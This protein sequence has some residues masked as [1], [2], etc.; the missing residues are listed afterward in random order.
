MLLVLEP[1]EGRWTEEFKT[2]LLQGTLP[3]KDE[4]AEHV[5]CQATG[6]CIQDG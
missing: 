5:A 1:Q 6:Y 3:K 4:D 2:Y